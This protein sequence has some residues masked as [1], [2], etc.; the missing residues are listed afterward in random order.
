[1]SKNNIKI[2]DKTF[3]DIVVDLIHLSKNSTKIIA[4]PS[5]KKAKSILSMLKIRQ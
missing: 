3:A 1:M 5:S 2:N 4:Y